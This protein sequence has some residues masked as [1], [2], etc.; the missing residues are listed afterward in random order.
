MSEK[1]A[2]Y[3]LVTTLDDIG[4]ILNLRGSD[5]ECNPVFV[6]YLLIGTNDIQLFI[7]PAKIPDELKNT[8][9]AA[10][11]KISNYDSISATLS[12]LTQSDKVLI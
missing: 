9:A 3:H 8:L 11:I 2:D 12:E 7:D 4:W 6:S 10:Q 5:V 1:G